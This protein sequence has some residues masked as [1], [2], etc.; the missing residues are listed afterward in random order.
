MNTQTKIRAII[1]G[2][3]WGRNPWAGLWPSSIFTWFPCAQGSGQ[4]LHARKRAYWGLSYTTTKNGSAFANVHKII[5]QEQAQAWLQPLLIHQTRR[6][7][8]G[9]VGLALVQVQ[10]TIKP[11]INTA[12]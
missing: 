9:Q 3:T 12:L 10:S 8:S 11:H 4:S 2:S 1:Q 7:Y 6:K 5:Y